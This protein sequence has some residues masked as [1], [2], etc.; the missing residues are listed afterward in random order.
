MKVSRTISVVVMAVL[1][2]VS[3]SSFTLHM[4]FCQGQ[5]Q[6]L[7]LLSEA[8]SCCMTK[9]ASPCQT[10]KQSTERSDKPCCEDQSV[11]VDGQEQVG[12]EVV[13][14]ISQNEFVVVLYS[15]FSFLAVSPA[16]FVDSFAAYTPPLILHDI[17]VL[18]QS[19]LI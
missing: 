14:T 10:H 11:V 6:N 4:H 19:F 8:R 15:L 18:V 2:L 3:S 13:V 7:S 5:I 12:N 9:S 16:A 1:V 17:P